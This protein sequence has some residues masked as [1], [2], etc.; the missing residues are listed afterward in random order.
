MKQGG[1]S[2]G[3]GRH[4]VGGGPSPARPRHCCRGRRARS[5]GHAGWSRSR[6]LP[7]VLGRR[8]HRH[9]RVLGRWQCA[10]AAVG[11]GWLAAWAGP[12]AGAATTPAPQAR[13][14]WRGCRPGWRTCRPGRA[15]AP[16]TPAGHAAAGSP[17]WSR[18]RA[19]MP[20]SSD[21]R[22]LRPSAGGEQAGDL[23]DQPHQPAHHQD[24][25]DGDQQQGVVGLVVLQLGAGQALALGPLRPHRRHL[26]AARRA[27]RG[28]Q[29][30]T[31]ARPAAGHAAGGDGRPR[32]SDAGRTRSNRRA[33]QLRWGSRRGA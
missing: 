27:G 19:R 29:P 25:A 1:P 4:G 5:A 10:S 11:R 28:S 14:G 12:V 21:K 31:G 15:A 26:P 6:R 32:R 3:E 18:R 24:G 30:Q 7:V 16:R 17:A 23:A 33:H 9:V 20:G 13:P 2:A 22:H 8:Q